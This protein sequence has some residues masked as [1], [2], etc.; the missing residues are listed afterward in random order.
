MTLREY[1]IIVSNGGTSLFLLFFQ[2]V[3]YTALIVKTSLFQT[4]HFSMLRLHCFKHIK[5]KG[6][7]QSKAACVETGEYA[8]QGTNKKKIKT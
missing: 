3:K 7:R 4:Y 8:K 6:V 2:N 5:I 1:R